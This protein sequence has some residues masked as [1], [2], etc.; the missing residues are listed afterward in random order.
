[1]RVGEWATEYLSDATHNFTLYSFEFR[2][3][4]I[5]DYGY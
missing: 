2:M 3:A 4:Y 5:I 1:M